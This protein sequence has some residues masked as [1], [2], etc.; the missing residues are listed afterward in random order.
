MGSMLPYIAA[1]WILWVDEP[2][3]QTAWRK[4]WPSPA[5]GLFSDEAP[6]PEAA[7]WTAAGSW[8]KCHRLPVTRMSV[9]KY[10]ILEMLDGQCHNYIPWKPVSFAHA[11]IHRTCVKFVW[12]VCFSSH[13]W[14]FL[15]VQVS[16]TC[17]D[18]HSPLAASCSYRTLHH[19]NLQMSSNICSWAVSQHI[20]IY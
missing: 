7:K 6:K 19:R 9:S 5:A 11:S 2:G 12:W 20:C 16:S 4:T 3:H 17:T 13:Q 1:P 10:R 8:S 18:Q 15:S 14:D